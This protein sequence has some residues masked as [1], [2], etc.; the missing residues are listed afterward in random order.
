MLPEIFHINATF[1]QIEFGA[2]HFEYPPNA[3]ALFLAVTPI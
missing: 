3:T 2:E 1:L